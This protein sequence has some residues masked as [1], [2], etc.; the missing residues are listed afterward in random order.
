M[1]NTSTNFER[2]PK[3]WLSKRSVGNVLTLLSS[4]NQNV[5]LRKG[6]LAMS[7]H[8]RIVLCPGTLRRQRVHRGAATRVYFLHQFC[9][10]LARAWLKNWSSSVFL[11]TSSRV[12]YESSATGIVTFDTSTDMDVAITYAWFTRLIGTP[13]TEYGPGATAIGRWTANEPRSQY[14]RLECV[15]SHHTSWWEFARTS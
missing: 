14:K 1:G 2:Q 10:T 11:A 15:G 6:V 9:F 5:G 4:V 3:C 7:S 12:K 13:F 8:T